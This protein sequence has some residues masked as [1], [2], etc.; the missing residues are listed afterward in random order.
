MKIIDISQELL[1]ADVYPGDPVPTLEPLSRIAL[2]DENY[3]VLRCMGSLLS[4]VETTDFSRSDDCIHCGR[5][6]SVCPQGLSPS[7]LC[8]YVRQENLA[9]AK[10]LGLEKCKLCGCCT[11]ICPG[12]VEITE[13]LK[14]GKK[15]IQ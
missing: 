5:C 2:G 11:Y 7:F 1:A 12:R 13:I 6:G 9:E 4:L 14:Q 10:L 8:E 15:A 3:T